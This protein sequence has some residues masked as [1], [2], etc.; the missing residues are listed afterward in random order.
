MPSVVID[1]KKRATAALSAGKSV[2]R[3]KPQVRSVTSSTPAPKAG[4]RPMTGPGL[5]APP[6]TSVMSSYGPPKG[7]GGDPTGA[8]LPMKDP[9]G[10]MPLPGG[11]MP[12]KPGMSVGPEMETQVLSEFGDGGGMMGMGVQP[13]PGGPLPP[14]YAGMDPAMAQQRFAAFR[15]GQLPGQQNQIA[16]YL[17]QL[18]LQPGLGSALPGGSPGGL[19]RMGRGTPYRPPQANWMGMGG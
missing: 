15:A 6:Q 11:G 17:Q 13:S 19:M 5:Q 2:L 3:K 4:P 18:G 8:G 16:S 12:M 7:P 10:G 1:P 14:R 9:S